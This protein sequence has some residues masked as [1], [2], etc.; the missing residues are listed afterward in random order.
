MKTPR[1]TYLNSRRFLVLSCF[2]I[3]DWFFRPWIGLTKF[4]GALGQK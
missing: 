4:L 2:W 3:L 1:K